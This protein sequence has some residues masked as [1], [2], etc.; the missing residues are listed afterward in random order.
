MKRLVTPFGNPAFERTRRRGRRVDNTN[1]MPVLVANRYARAL[2][3]VVREDP[4][5][6]VDELRNFLSAYKESAELREVFDT[7]SIPLAEKIKLIDAIQSRLASSAVTTNFLRVLATNF[8]MN[9][10]DEILPA[11]ARIVNERMGIV[12]VKIF[13]ATD[14]SSGER[15]SLA[16]R[17]REATHKEVEMEFHR[18]ED[19]LGGI[20]AQVQSTVY[21]GSIRGRLERIREELMAG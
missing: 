16:A 3:D 17:F 15:E 12:H 9:L 18:Q 7:P 6:V 11:F 2:G 1:P 10:L 19:L 13:S 21:D 14:L 5:R 8:R 4:R 20:V